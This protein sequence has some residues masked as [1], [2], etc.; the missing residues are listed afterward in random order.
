MTTG[1]EEDR[2][3]FEVLWSAEKAKVVLQEGE[4]GLCF[5]FDP[6]QAKALGQKLIDASAKVTQ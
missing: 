1:D 2:G 5:I 6:D 4:S 3:S